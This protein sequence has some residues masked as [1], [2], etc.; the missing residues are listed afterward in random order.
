MSAN[1]IA[2]ALLSLNLVVVV[3]FFF[4]PLIEKY[5]IDELMYNDEW[6]I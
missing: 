2:A 4:E 6:L 3:D 5:V 1:R